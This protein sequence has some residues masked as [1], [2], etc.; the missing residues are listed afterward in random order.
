MKIL[1][2]FKKKNL[3]D[4]Y[5]QYK[6]NY[7]CMLF[8]NIVYILHKFFLGTSLLFYWMHLINKVDYFFGWN[9]TIYMLV[10]HKNLY[11]IVVKLLKIMIFL[12]LLRQMSNSFYI[13]TQIRSLLSIHSLSNMGRKWFWN[14]LLKCTCKVHI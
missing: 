10:N 1:N 14:I 7:N 4:L 12:N 11:L 5:T 2:F 6:W 13:C 3:R 9:P 8:I